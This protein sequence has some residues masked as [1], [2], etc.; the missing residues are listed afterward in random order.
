M[1]SMTL[2][3]NAS[4]I[5]ADFARGISWDNPDREKRIALAAKY[6]QIIL[7]PKT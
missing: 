6:G 3:E 7:K 4:R 1:I 2:Q 5:F